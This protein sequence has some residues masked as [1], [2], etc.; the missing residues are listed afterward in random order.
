MATEKT[1][2]ERG[3]AHIETYQPI[4]PDITKWPIYRL[5][6]S[7]YEFMEEV[8]KM[9]VQR[10][11]EK[12][13]NGNH[14][15]DELARTVYQERI[16][17]TQNPW[18]AD[19][20]D[21][22]EFWSDVRRKLIRITRNDPPNK[23]ETLALVKAIVSRYTHEI[24]G[25]FDP[26]VYEFARVAVP[27]GISRLLNST[28][29]RNLRER[30]S[31]QFSIRDRVVLKGD[32]A[33]IREL[34]KNHT[35]VI[36]PTHISNID[37]IVIG[38]AIQE[39]GLPAFI[40]GAGLNLFGIRLLAYFMNRLGAYKVD[41][42]KKNQIYLETLKTYSALALHREC[43][44]LFFPGGTRS[45]SGAIES[46]LKL[47]LLGT[48]LDAQYM[49]YLAFGP[50]AKKIIIV[51]V[52]MNYHFVLEAPNLIEEHL[53]KTGREF[54]L[55]EKPDSLSTSLR[56]I[57]FLI[58]FLTASSKMYL[59]F[60]PCMDLFGNRVERDGT[61]Y[62]ARGRPVDI[63][64]YFIS[65]DK[66]VNDHQRNEEYVKMLGEIIVQ[67]YHQYNIA[68]T[69][70]LVAFVA[71]EMI[72]KTY[73]RLDIFGLLRLPPEDTVLPWSSFLQSA[74]RVLNRLKELERQNCIRLTE[75]M[76]QSLDVIINRGLEQVGL[77]HDRRPLVRKRNGDI[78]SPDL[79]LL[80]FYHNRLL[81][82]NLE[83]YV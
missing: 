14:L 50:R 55:I 28:I 9:S 4:E 70:H 83:A 10:L 78:M 36:V 25:T 62:D 5:S 42:R 75:T 81:G 13:P 56:I 65:D 68:M 73:K 54:Y 59:Y 72:Q 17:I 27:F 64:G 19:P 6:A 37:S 44:S 33:S 57:K 38:W 69:S 11:L 80:Y 15:I 34:A 35:L 43:H 49:N 20:A 24:S 45:R 58:K 61:S 77:Y 18:K 32:I 46:R 23:E 41:R 53:K 51:P 82:Y 74:E 66:L 16:R 8:K 21:E 1:I 63:K 48:T 79:K 7:R 39:I 30:F 76:H 40:Y 67:R 60:C 29:G 26:S 52:V 31:Q 71:F 3:Q 47:G 2:P 12:S 22:W